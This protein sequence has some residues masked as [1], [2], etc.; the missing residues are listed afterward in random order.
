MQNY[1]GE[2]H[3]RY[4][5]NVNDLLSNAAVHGAAK[6]EGISHQTDSESHQCTTERID[7]LNQNGKP[8]DIGKNS[9]NSDD[10]FTIYVPPKLETKKQDSIDLLSLDMKFKKISIDG[11]ESEVDK[12]HIAITDDSSTNEPN[13]LNG[14]NGDS[15]DSK[16]LAG[17]VG[18][19]FIKVLIDESESDHI[20]L[21]VNDNQ[22]S[23]TA[24]K[25]EDIP[26]QIDSESHQCTTE[27]LDLLNQNG[28]QADIGKNSENSDDS[29]T[30]YVPP[31]LE[32][33]KQEF[34][35]L[36][37]LDTEKEES[38]DLKNLDMKF[39]KISIERT[40][41]TGMK[42]WDQLKLR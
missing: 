27:R 9:E 8:A 2:S 29:F 39:K 17:K 6:E 33:K 35:D 11:K 16:H 24:V 22:L 23:N 41:K 31:K 32:T 19:E 28:K 20:S 4:F 42:V 18:D 13:K 15:I 26:H 34:I 1:S 36:Q 3:F 40:T 25:E 10:S 30:I 38:I 21:N 12:G 14:N 7:L 5:S 37:N